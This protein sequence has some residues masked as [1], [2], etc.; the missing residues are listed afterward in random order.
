V[1]T[2]IKGV[3]LSPVTSSSFASCEAMPANP[4]QVHLELE[5]GLCCPQGPVSQAHASNSTLAPGD[6]PPP[7]NTHLLAD[8]LGCAAP[9][10]SLSFSGTHFICHME[11][12][13]GK[14]LK[15]Q[16]LVG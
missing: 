4:C 11:V 12:M 9:S 10:E 5:D 16:R 2:G 3:P 14:V 7:P 13:Q 6:P 1:G 8:L 15:G